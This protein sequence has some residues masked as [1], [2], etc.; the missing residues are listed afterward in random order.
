MTL[1]LASGAPLSA[2]LV[3]ASHAA[4]DHTGLPG[5]GD[6]STAGHAATNHA[7]LPGVGDLTTAGHAA[8]NHAGLPGVGDLSTATHASL[9]HTGIPGIPT[10]I[11]AIGVATGTAGSTIVVPAN[12]VST[13]GSYLRFALLSTSYP[14]GGGNS[15]A[16]SF[17][18]VS[19]YSSGLSSGGGP[20][21]IE[22]DVIYL[23]GTSW[24]VIAKARGTTSTSE[25]YS[26][27]TVNPGVNQNFTFSV[28]AGNFATV[29]AHA[30]R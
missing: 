15:V 19:I 24:Q 13:A 26:S 20:F 16:V 11:G 9:D 3:P 8:T 1:G 18:G 6:L 12:T 22:V 23:G 7:G 4:V 17:G 29:M 2:A 30:H 21:L 28:T 25:S 10:A 27:I 5:V 14:G